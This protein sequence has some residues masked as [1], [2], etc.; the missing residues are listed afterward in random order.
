MQ[1]DLGISDRRRGQR[2]ARQQQQKSSQHKLMLTWLEK[3]T[4]E[5]LAARAKL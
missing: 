3:K 4:K 2:S 1:N 5:N